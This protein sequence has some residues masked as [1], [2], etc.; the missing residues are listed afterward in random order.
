MRDQLENQIKNLSAGDY[1]KLY[2]NASDELL[3]R[4]YQEASLFVL[5]HMLLSNGDTEGCPTVFSEAMGH[6][7]PLIGGT[8]AGADTAIISGKNGYIVNVRNQKE[9]I[10]KIK[11]ILNNKELSKKMIEFGKEK[12]SRDHDPRKAGIA[13]AKTVERIILG[14]LAEGSQLY[15]N[16]IDKNHETE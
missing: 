10:S 14:K 9:L 5:A 8:G 2:N 7:L 13:L 11:E 3:S 4:K 1:I 12:L 16:E 6:G 15:F